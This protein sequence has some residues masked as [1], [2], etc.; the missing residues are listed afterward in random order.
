MSSGEQRIKIS[1]DGNESYYGT[2]VEFTVNVEVSRDGSKL[3]F[4][5][6]PTI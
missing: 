6:N 2:E 3:E 1:Y 4:C 5:E